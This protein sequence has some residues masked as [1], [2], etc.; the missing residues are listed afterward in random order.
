ATSRGGRLAPVFLPT[1]GDADRDA[2]AAPALALEDEL[3]HLKLH[4]HR[5]LAGEAGGAEAVLWLLDGAHQ[6]LDR[7]VREA[8]RADVLADLLD[9]LLGGDQLPLRRHVDAEVAGVADRRGA[10]AHVHLFRARLAQHLDDFRGRRATDDRVVDDDE[11]LALDHLP[12]RVE[13]QVYTLVAH[14]LVRLDEGA[15]DVAVL[16]ETFRI[17]DARLMRVPD[18]RRRGGVRH[19]NNQVGLDGRLAGQL[20]PHVHAH[21]VE[22]LVADDAVGSGEVD[23]LE[24][25]EGVALLLNG[26]HRVKALFVDNDRLTGLDFAHEVRAEVVE[27]AGLGGDNP[28]VAVELADTERAYAIGV[29]HRDQ[30]VGREGDEAVGAGE[31][32]HRV[33]GALEPVR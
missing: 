10:D 2:L 25:A 23:V 1:P 8:V 14:A 4:G 9:L 28:A 16:D 7:E 21:W 17:R 29:S 5:V 15:A 6:G 24:D 18:R 33:R 11:A 19:A 31:R 20:T 32:L 12:H 26:L 27:S 30:H 13:L 3:V 22:Q